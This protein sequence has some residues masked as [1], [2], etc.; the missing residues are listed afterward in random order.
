MLVDVV[1]TEVAAVLGHEDTG[2]IG[3]DAVFFDIGFVS[4]TAVELRN[5]L[6]NVTGLELPALLAFDQPT[7]ERLAG[8]LLSLLDEAVLDEAVLDGTVPSDTVPAEQR[9]EGK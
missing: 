6:Q 5:R 3:A 1:R 4:L 9:T 7:P 8:H 2:E